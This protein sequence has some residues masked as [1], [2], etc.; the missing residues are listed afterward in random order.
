MRS[1]LSAH[2]HTETG[3]NFVS[4][5][6][7]WRLKDVSPA[8]ESPKVAFTINVN[9]VDDM[10]TIVPDSSYAF[11]EDSMPGGKT[12]ELNL[13][14][15]EKSH[16]L[17]GFITKLPD[18]GELYAVNGSGHRT[19]IDD[20]YNPFDVGEP[21]VR[22]YLSRVVRVSSFWGSNPPCTRR[23]PVAC[24]QRAVALRDA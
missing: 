6:V 12:I 15:A 18:L 2:A 11:D 3:T 10:S 17:S 22:Q 24:R 4:F 14:D 23:R 9:A 5:E 1:F 13:T 8:L 16:I 21:V 20:Y 7:A 19:H